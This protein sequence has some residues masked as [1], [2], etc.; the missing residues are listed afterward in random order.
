MFSLW[1]AR[2]AGATLG[3]AARAA[4]A[5]SSTALIAASPGTIAGA[6][7]A[8]HATRGAPSLRAGPATVR[9]QRWTRAVVSLTQGPAMGRVRTEPWP[10]LSR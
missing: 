2:G 6:V 8:A 1:C 7:G 10:S 5:R 3:K 4:A 9:A